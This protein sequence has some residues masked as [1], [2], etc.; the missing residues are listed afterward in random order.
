MKQTGVDLGN[1]P[2]TFNC[3]PERLKSQVS[4]AVSFLLRNTK[5]ADRVRSG[6]M[7]QRAS[8]RGSEVSAAAFAGPLPAPTFI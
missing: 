1:I 7:G 8:E 2:I 5:P 3:S 6:S 4:S